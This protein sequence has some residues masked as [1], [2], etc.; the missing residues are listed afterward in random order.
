MRWLGVRASQRWRGDKY[1]CIFAPQSDGA[2]KNHRSGEER[3]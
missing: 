2:F 3:G 1:S